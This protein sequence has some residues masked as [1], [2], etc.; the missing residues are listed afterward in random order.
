MTFNLHVHIQRA[1]N[2]EYYCMAALTTVTVFLFRHEWYW[3]LL[4]EVTTHFGLHTPI[5]KLIITI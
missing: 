3:G 2:H 1:G 5:R 4:I